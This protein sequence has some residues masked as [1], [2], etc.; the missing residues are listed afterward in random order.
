MLHH[1]SDHEKKTEFFKSWIRNSRLLHHSTVLC[2][3]QINLSTGIR[4]TTT[5]TVKCL[6]LV[7]KFGVSSRHDASALPSKREV[8]NHRAEKLL[9]QYS[10]NLFCESTVPVPS[11]AIG[12]KSAPSMNVV[13]LVWIAPMYNLNLSTNLISTWLPT[14]FRGKP[15]IN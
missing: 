6:S 1:G 7:L 14:R 13:N 2:C 3:A 11:R 10:W 4:I 5:L 15:W 9:L 8:S 12:L